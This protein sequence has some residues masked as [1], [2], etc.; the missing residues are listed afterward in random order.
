MSKKA[1]AIEKDTSLEHFAEVLKGSTK[2]GLEAILG[3]I[4][5]SRRTVQGTV[6]M[7]YSLNIIGES[8]KNC[9]YRI[10]PEGIV[11]T[12]IELIDKNKPQITAMQDIQGPVKMRAEDADAICYDKLKDY[13]EINRNDLFARCGCVWNNK[14]KEK[15]KSQTS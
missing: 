11:I 5:Q 6:Y 1:R 2:E 10:I 13:V 14:F 9:V 7:G 3:H 4:A 15:I 8:V 12:W